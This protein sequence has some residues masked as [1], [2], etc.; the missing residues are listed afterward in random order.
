MKAY[1]LGTLFG[2]TPSPC[3]TPMIIAMIAFASITG[4]LV[5]STL[6]LLVYGIGHGTPFLIIGWLARVLKNTRW[7]VRWQKLLSKAIGVG[8]FLVGLYFFFE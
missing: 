3:T 5:K 6:L 1:S 4:S 8:L 7:M 2:L